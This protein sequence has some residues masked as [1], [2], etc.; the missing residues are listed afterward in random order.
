MA[1]LGLFWQSNDYLIQ[2]LKIKY[3]Y[4]INIIVKLTYWQSFCRIKSHIC[5]IAAHS[6][7]NNKLEVALSEKIVCSI[8]ITS[9]FTLSNRKSIKSVM[10]V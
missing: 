6:G 7:S 3:T 8:K 4:N 5:I 10:S 9:V 1:Y 2:Q